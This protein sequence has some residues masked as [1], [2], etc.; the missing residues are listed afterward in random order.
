MGYAGTVLFFVTS[1]AIGVMIASSA[2]VSRAIG[3]RERDAAN[4]L[5][6]SGLIFMILVTGVMVVAMMSFTS[7]LLNS[8]WRDWRY[9]SSRIALFAFHP[10]RYGFAWSCVWR[11]R[12]YCVR[13]W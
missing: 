1:V 2:L 12:G 4:R 11:Q 6:A 10:A 13:W 8:P 3:A 9:F 5:A 7:P